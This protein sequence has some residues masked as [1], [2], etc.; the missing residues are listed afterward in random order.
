MVSV[1]IGLLFSALALSG[2][3]SGSRPIIYA[4]GSQ[5]LFNKTISVPR[6]QTAALGFATSINPD[7][8]HSDARD[9]VVLTQSPS[10]GRVE[11]RQDQG[12]A[13][14]RPANPRSRC[15][16]QRVPGIKVFYHANA[17]A[18][19]TD[20]FSYDWYTGTGAIAHHNVTVNL[21]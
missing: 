2:C 20:S 17:G 8:S 1:R 18:S 4:G 21:M 13:Y 19:G 9:R 16:N 7:C 11:I 15:N 5:A 3:N 10:Q 6:G 12:Y 14:F